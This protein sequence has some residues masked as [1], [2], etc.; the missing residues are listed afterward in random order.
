VE[1]A[2]W[3]IPSDEVQG[4]GCAFGDSVHM[5]IPRE[6][7]ADIQAELFSSVNRYQGCIM[8]GVVIHN[9]FGFLD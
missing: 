7:A 1:W 9:W 8:Q 4:M 3:E 5:A 2:G 6:F